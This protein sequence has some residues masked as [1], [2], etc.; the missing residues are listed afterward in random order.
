GRRKRKWLRRIGK[1]VK[2][3]GGAALDHL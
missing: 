2:I 3:I 1:G